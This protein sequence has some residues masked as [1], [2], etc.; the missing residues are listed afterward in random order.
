MARLLRSG[1]PQRVLVPPSKLRLWSGVVLG[2]ALPLAVTP[3]ATTGPFERFPTL[4][5]LLAVVA[6]TLLGRLAAGAVAVVASSLLLIYYFVGPRSFLPRSAGEVVAVAG[7][8]L[9]AGL[10]AEI[11]ARQDRAR[12]EAAA[13][14]DQLRLL[15][16]AGDVLE[17]SLDY[18]RTLAQ[19][20][21]LLVPRFADWAGVALAEED[22]TYTSLAIAHADPE[23]VRFAEELQERYPP[24]QDAPTGV[25]NV[26][27]TGT[28]ELYPEITDQMLVDAAK[29][30]LERLRIVRELGMSSAIIAPLSARGRTLGALTLVSAESGRHYDQDD[31]AVAEQLAERAA[32]A[33]DNARLYEEERAAKQRLA[34]AAEVTEL[35]AES[36]DYEGLFERLAR[37]VV[38]NLADLCLIDVLENDRIERVAAVSADPAKQPLADELR[39]RYAP[40][41]EGVHPVSRVIRGGEPEHSAEMTDAYLRETTRDA[42]HLELVRAFGFQS[43]ICVPLE[44]RGRILGTLT[45][46]ST[47]PAHRYGPSDVVSAFEIARRAA[48]RI[49]NARLYQERDHIARTLQ[50]SLLPETLPEVPGLEV[51]ARYQPSGTGTE[52]GGDFYDLF[53]SGTDAWTLMIGDVCGKG[54]E[55]AAITGVARHT[56]RAL[57]IRGTRP[58]QLLESLNETLLSQISDQR[59]L[60]AC[61]ARIRLGESGARMTV[62]SGGHPL[63]VLVSRDGAIE[64]IGQHGTALGVFAD[65]ELTDRMVT[66]QPGDAVVFY[67]DGLEGPRIPVEDR[68]QDLLAGA[69]GL[70]AA[71]VA[72]RLLQE[73]G[74]STRARRDD[75]AIVVLRVSP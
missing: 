1:R 44:T 65:V 57:A 55:A 25:P 27:R 56:V 62:C 46:V 24:E 49:D 35:L 4:L 68:V 59:F 7:F 17:A 72:D 32:L 16:E 45:M 9:V 42:R 51:A 19:L 38:R 54:A 14:Q 33:I 39:V 12:A 23:K 71:A 13:T 21:R 11:L 64:L 18:Q 37:V 26:I 63:P 61:S 58:S 60:T 22:G 31:L 29:G 10:V 6:A 69:E 2:V 53:P 3:L 67:T 43:F 48:L 30:D 73:A 74:P 28:A 34:L 5:Y 52:V 70:P 47:D 75:V 8:V 41:I 15:A 36:L 50:E 40:R 20:A 66:L